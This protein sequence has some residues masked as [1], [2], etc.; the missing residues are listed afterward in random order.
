M[1]KKY[2]LAAAIPVIALAGFGV[3]RVAAAEGGYSSF[4]ERLAE[5]LGVSVE[6]VE[7]ALD[8]TRAEGREEHLDRAVENGVLTEDQKVLVEQKSEE[9]KSEIDA[10]RESDMTLE[11]QRDA[12]HEVMDS[13]RTWAEENDIPAGMVNGGGM[14]GR[15][16]RGGIK[17][18]GMGG[19]GGE[20]M[21]L[22]NGECL[23]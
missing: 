14:M 10:I 17:G 22:G 7:T 12:M 16:A 8:E 2:L 15:G 23:E 18:E 20:G 4:A 3:T 11:E 21:G 9:V 13:T 5:K 19:F 6:S 1:N